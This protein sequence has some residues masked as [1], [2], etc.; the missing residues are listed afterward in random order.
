MTIVWFV[1]HRSECKRLNTV[2]FGGHPVFR[3]DGISIWIDEQ[4][5][6]H[7]SS[8]NLYMVQAQPLFAVAQVQ[9]IYPQSPGSVYPIAMP[10]QM[11]PQLPQQ[12]IRTA[13]VDF[14]LLLK[15]LSFICCNFEFLV[16]K[17]MFSTHKILII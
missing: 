3:N 8:V 6:P 2:Y 9:P 4:F 13:Q 5:I 11:T 14:T 15:F 12:P 10:V 1:V 7:N 17:L 16:Y